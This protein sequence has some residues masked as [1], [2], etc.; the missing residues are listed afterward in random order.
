MTRRRDK[1]PQPGRHCILCGKA[2]GSGMT[3]VIRMLANVYRDKQLKPPFDDSAL[4]DVKAHG[5]CVIEA[6]RKAA[7]L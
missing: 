5:N 6:R 7:A 2:G 3:H 1:Q 4:H